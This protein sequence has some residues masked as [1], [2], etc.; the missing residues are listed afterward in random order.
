MTAALFDAR[1]LLE[2][3]ATVRSWDI[4]VVCR[5]APSTPFDFAQGGRERTEVYPESPECS[6]TV[7]TVLVTMNVAHASPV[8]GDAFL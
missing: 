8:V 7:Q 3:S 2:S 5:L 4:E 1:T 6:P